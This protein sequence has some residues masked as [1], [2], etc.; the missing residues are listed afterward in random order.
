M[1]FTWG[2]SGEIPERQ[3]LKRY[4]PKESCMRT[5]SQDIFFSAIEGFSADFKFREF[6]LA[7]VCRWGFGAKKRPVKL[8]QYFNNFIPYMNKT[9]VTENANPQT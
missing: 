3:I 1:K 2:C 8:G 9:Q 4:H 6:I 7:V 5:R